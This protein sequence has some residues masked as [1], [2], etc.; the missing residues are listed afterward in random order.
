M[1]FNSITFYNNTG[2]YGG[3][4]LYHTYRIHL[5]GPLI[6]ERNT[7]LFDGAVYIAKPEIY[8][9]RVVLHLNK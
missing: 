7:A 8:F 6:F 4:I 5:T 9:L 3:G 1:Y 2:V